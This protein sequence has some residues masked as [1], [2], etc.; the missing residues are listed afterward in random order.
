MKKIIIFA[1]LVI[2]ILALV[3]TIGTDKPIY[4]CTLEVVCDDAIASGVLSA[5]KLELLPADGV[6]LAKTD[7]KFA[8]GDSVM[9]VLQKTLIENKIHYDVQ[10]ISSTGSKYLRGIANLYQNDCGEYSG[11]SYYINDEMP[12]ESAASYKLK[13]GDAIRF[14]YIS[15]FTKQN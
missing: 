9:D 12:S 6:V 5:E 10:N 7:V 14:V 3:F 11:W 2:A 13:N 1:V 4:D 15:D 8:K